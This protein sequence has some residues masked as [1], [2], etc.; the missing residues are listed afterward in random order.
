MANIS[1]AKVGDTLLITEMDYGEP[2]D[3]FII[4]VV[5]LTKTQVVAS[6][7]I[8]EIDIRFYKKSGTMVDC[9]RLD[10]RPVASIATKK[11]IKRVKDDILNENVI[12]DIQSTCLREIPTKELIPIRDQIKHLVTK[13][14]LINNPEELLG[15]EDEDE[16]DDLITFLGL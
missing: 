10:F 13:Y 1:K 14:T 8:N 5:R 12:H 2:Y 7:S 15:G 6:R 11:D 16:E 4:E 9:G 3:E